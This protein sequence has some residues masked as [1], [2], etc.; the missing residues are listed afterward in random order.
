[1][2]KRVMKRNC[3]D[4]NSKTKTFMTKIYRNNNNNNNNIDLL[5]SR[6]RHNTLSPHGRQKMKQKKYLKIKSA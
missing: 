6:K 5:I 4:R 1:M 3:Y 2:N